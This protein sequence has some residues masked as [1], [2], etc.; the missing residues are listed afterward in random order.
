MVGYNN[1]NTD[2]TKNVSKYMQQKRTA[3]GGDVKENYSCSRAL[4][5]ER[6]VKHLIPGGKR[7]R[8]NTN[9]KALQRFNGQAVWGDGIDDINTNSSSGNNLLPLDKHILCKL[10]S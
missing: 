6:V 3:P 5:A 8:R 9:L 7:S 2:S 1:Q 10:G 4:W